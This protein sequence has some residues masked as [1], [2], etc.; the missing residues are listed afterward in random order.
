MG[1]FLSIPI[2]LLAAVL[3]GT[4]IPQIR[5][6][7]GAPDLIFL[8]V[9]AWAM[10]SEIEEGVIWAFVGGIAQDLQ[11]I[12]P[13]GISTFGM[14]IIVF[15]ISGLAQRVYGISSLIF[16][17]IA[18]AIFGTLFH[19]LILMILLWLT[20][21]SI[22]WGEDITNVVAPTIFYNLVLILPIYWFV[23][24]I[25]RRAIRPQRGTLS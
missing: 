13:L 7:N 21:H 19:Q 1:R 2:L 22:S 9:I 23:R 20:G 15:G 16:S 24:R 17:L 14:L 4:L 8:L 5:I 25:Q 11:S 12:A 6:G 18:I 10:N 3:H